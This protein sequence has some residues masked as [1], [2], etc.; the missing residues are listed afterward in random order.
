MSD[1][2]RNGGTL[3]DPPRPTLRDQFAMAAITGMLAS[4]P[5][6]EWHNFGF[7]GWAAKAAYICADAMMEA[8]GAIPVATE[9]K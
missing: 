4:E 2:F 7:Y 6:Q 5:L 1:L 8:R 9:A 3:A